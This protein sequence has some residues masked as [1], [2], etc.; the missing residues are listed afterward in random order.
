MLRYAFVFST[1]VTIT[2]LSTFSIPTTHM[3]LA[4]TNKNSGINSNFVIYENHDHGIK[5]QYPSG[6]K[7]EEG[8][9]PHFS[10][11]FIVPLKNDSSTPPALFRLGVEKLPS[12]DI[13]LEKFTNEQIADTKQTY[14]VFT[15]WHINSTTVAGNNT[16]KQ[17][18]FSATDDKHHDAKAMQIF[19]IKNNI[20][21][22]ITYIAKP[23]SYSEF[24]PVAKK[25]IDSFEI[26]S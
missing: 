11:S 12:H 6:W 13:S 8:S 26:T 15:L 24:L 10:V 22:H 4:Q 5:I 25:M 1:I 14:P 21:Y 20:S 7:V 2:M 9:L 19:V 3:T 23:E 18:V 17:L 16:A